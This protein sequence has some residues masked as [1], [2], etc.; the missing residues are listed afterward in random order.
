MRRSGC[1]S[2]RCATL[3]LIGM[4]V[5]VVISA[6]T[7]PT[8]RWGRES[9]SLIDGGILLNYW[10]FGCKWSDFADVPHLR[11]G[12]EPF[13]RR[14]ERPPSWYW[15][16]AKGG[17]PFSNGRIA[18]LPL[19]ILLPPAAVSAWALWPRRYHP[20]S[21]LNCGYNLTANGS[22]RCPECGGLARGS[23][24][25]EGGRTSHVRARVSSRGSLWGKPS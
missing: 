4:T 9:L 2:S 14:L 24:V 6:F 17:V 20:P 3:S 21:C 25:T 8:L 18:Y 15:L 11:M 12:F 13:W 23:T 1:I 10:S 19:Y 16:P 22:E 5:L 7:P